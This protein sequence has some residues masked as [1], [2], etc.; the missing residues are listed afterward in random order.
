MQGLV[1]RTLLA[2]IAGSLFGVLLYWIQ[3]DAPFFS[4][5][6]P[7]EKYH[8]AYQKHYDIL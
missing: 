1:Q 3:Y 2:G 7:H 5:F 4:G 8:L 6:R